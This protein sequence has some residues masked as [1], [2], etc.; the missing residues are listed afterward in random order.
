MIS[1][2]SDAFAF[3]EAETLAG[4]TFIWNYYQFLFGTE[5]LSVYSHP[6]V[7]HGG[8]NITHDDANYRNA[9]CAKIGKRVERATSN[10]KHLELVFDDGSKLLVSFRPEDRVARELQESLVAT[11]PQGNI[12]VIGDS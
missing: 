2:S 4:V 12:L 7:I 6:I 1:T 10:E 9:L 8:K 11:N 5:T 3:L